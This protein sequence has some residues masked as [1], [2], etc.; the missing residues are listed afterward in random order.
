MAIGLKKEIDYEKFKFSIVSIFGLTQNKYLD[1]ETETQQ[2]IL[3]ED[4]G[5]F[6]A[7]NYKASKEIKLI[8]VKV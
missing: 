1:L 6:A 5:Q 3:K 7:A 4:F 2:T 8:T